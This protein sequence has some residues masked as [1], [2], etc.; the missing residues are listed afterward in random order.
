MLPPPVP[1]ILAMLQ[2]A[3]SGGPP[4][5]CRAAMAFPLSNTQILTARL[6][7]SPPLW[8]EKDQEGSM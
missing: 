6:D 7:T 5:S 8:W 1:S 3:T 2:L 4:F